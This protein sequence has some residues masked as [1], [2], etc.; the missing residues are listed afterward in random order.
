MFERNLYDVYGLYCEE[1]FSLGGY[2]GFRTGNQSYLLLPKEE[3]MLDEQD[4]ITF[5]EYLR[6]VGDTSV[7]EPINT[8][9]NKRVALID[10]QEV[11]V[12]ALP[13]QRAET[14]FYL[15]SLEE[16]GAH[17]A[18][19]HYYGKQMK[20]EKEYEYFGQWAHLWEARLEQLE[21]W[22]QQVLFQG[23]QTDVDQAFLFTY[24]YFMGLTENAIQYA[25]DATL[26]DS[27]RDQ[28]VPTIC[29]RRYTD[30]T[31]IPISE[32]GSIVKKP[33]EWL[34]DHPCRDIAEWIRDQRRVK[35]VFPWQNLDSFL[36]GYEQYEPL[37]SF[38]WR[39]LY[40]RLLFPL[41]YFE[42]IENY[43][44][45]QIHEE[46][47][48]S[49][50]EFLKLLDDEKKNEQFLKEFAANYLVSRQTEGEQI[51]RISWL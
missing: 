17:L 47:A 40:A 8:K 19:V 35:D 2:E 13:E 15:N 46:K 32:Q 12:C 10:G 50:F 51:P 31:W 30:R 38:S 7:L 24:P 20:Y 16:K 26:D 43:Y 4:M 48:E 49:R 45:S 33:T 1:R 5:T 34:Y 11:Y 27:T 9:F 28:E 18:T 6:S 36:R 39:L 41:H 44:K 3:S 21:G 14:H 23:P 22:Y 42:T 25:V 37:T 29:H